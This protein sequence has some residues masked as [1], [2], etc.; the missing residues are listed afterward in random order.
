MS[1]EA[2]ALVGHEAARRAALAAAAAGR[3]E[4]VWLLSGEEGIGKRRFAG[5]LAAARWCEVGG[6]AAGEPCGRCRA[7]RQVES[8]NHPDLLVLAR[9]PDDPDDFGSRFEITVDQVRHRV[10][11]HFAL[12]AVQGGGRTV[13]VDEADRLNEPAQNA[14]LKTLEE[15]PPA[16]LVLLVAAHPEALLETVRSRCREL[17][18][19][20]L[21]AEELARLHPGATEAQLRAAG[22]RPGRVEAL[23]SLDLE[24]LTAALDAALGG[25]AAG[26][27]FARALVELVDASLEQ[28]PAAE[29]GDRHRLAVEVLL[30]ALAEREARDPPPP[31]AQ[32]ALLEV[33]R[34]LVRHIPPFQAWLAAGEALSGGQVGGRPAARHHS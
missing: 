23:A 12:R 4:G 14:L 1:P 9:D 21:R 34:D 5:W 20:P 6:P 16:A 18:L 24:R 3:L 28:R 7:C 30:G 13:I 32:E 2:G 33:A 31:Q 26:G 19:F 25:R 17:R 10:L 8:G 29:A 15:P 27:D 11:P 22:G